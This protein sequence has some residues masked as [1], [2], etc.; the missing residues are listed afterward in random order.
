[1]AKLHYLLVNACGEDGHALP[2]MY[3]FARQVAETGCI[4]AYA[5]DGGQTTALV[6]DNTLVNRVLLNYQRKI[7]DIIYFATAIPNS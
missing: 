5:L 6:M 2:N 1:M 7:T 4:N 3:Q